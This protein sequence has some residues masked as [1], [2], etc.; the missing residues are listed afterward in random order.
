MWN[1]RLSQETTKTH[2]TEKDF[3]VRQDLLVLKWGQLLLFLKI[4][5]RSR[6]FSLRESTRRSVNFVVTYCNSLG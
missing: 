6:R 1:K 4:F 2:R 3:E 5:K